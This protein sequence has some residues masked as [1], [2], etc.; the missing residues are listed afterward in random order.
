MPVLSVWAGAR[1]P[2][3]ETKEESQELVTFTKVQTGHVTFFF[4]NV[5]SFVK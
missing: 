3:E 4:R 1:H 5:G 2:V